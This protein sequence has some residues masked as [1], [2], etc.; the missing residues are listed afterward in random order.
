MKLN[1][2][3]IDKPIIVVGDVHGYY[4]TVVSFIK[5]KTPFS[6]L[7]QP[8]FKLPMWLVATI[9]TV[10]M[11]NMSSEKVLFDGADLE[12]GRKEMDRVQTGTS[13]TTETRPGSGHSHSAIFE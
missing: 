7:R 8:H 5:I 10:Q 3:Y 4:N 11:Q 6:Q 13:V 9:Q 2:I 12:V 1:K